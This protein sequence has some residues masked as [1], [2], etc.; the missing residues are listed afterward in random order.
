M[1]IGE[2]WGKFG[3]LQPTAVVMASLM[4]VYAF[5]MLAAWFFERAGAVVGL[6]TLAAFFAILAVINSGF[7][8]NPLL[9]V[10]WLPVV[11]YLFCWVSGVR[12]RSTT[13][14]AA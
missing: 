3:K 9:L 7:L 6:V 8:L 10:F 13:T 11:L 4:T 5:S 12:N 14:S 2:T 1:F